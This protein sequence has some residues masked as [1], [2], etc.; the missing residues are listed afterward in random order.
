MDV[1]QGMNLTDQIVSITYH[2]IKQL[3]NQRMWKNCLK[4]W[5]LFAAEFCIT[6]WGDNYVQEHLNGE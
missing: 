6:D 3:I 2:I 1:F 4:S 5:H